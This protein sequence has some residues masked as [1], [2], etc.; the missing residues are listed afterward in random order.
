MDSELLTL[1]S[2]AAI[3]KS[4]AYAE[5]T[6]KTYASMRL[7]YLRLCAYFGFQPVP[8]SSSTVVLYVTFLARSL[9]PTSLPG[10]L[11]IVRLMHCEL[12]LTN[13]LD[14]CDVRWVRT[15]IQRR[16][17]QPPKQKL[18]ITPTILHDMYLQLDLSD[19]YV[20][21]FWAA[22]LVGFFAFLRKSSLLPKDKTKTAHCLCIGDIG[23]RKD[24]GLAMLT[25]R[26][27]KTIQFGQRVLCI[28]LSI[29]SN[30]ALCPVTALRRLLSSLPSSLPKDTP[31]FSFRS[32]N[33]P[34]AS[35]TYHT[36]IKT[37][38]STLKRAGY[39][40]LDYSGHSFR[41]GGCSH[42]FRLGVPAA[43]IKSRGDWR[44]SAYERYIT[45]HEQMNINVA[46][47]LVS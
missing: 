42:A 23:F 36:F 13:P 37:L 33:S 20:L 18:A 17:G 4:A 14:N 10:Y 46:R 26:H 9:K 44:S 1:R 5:S 25:V 7:A 47:I 3:F 28:P 41:R 38:K 21:A 11:N 24:D 32:G 35:L 19:S 39:S 16:L 31:L 12:G 2:E 34:V 43:L 29:H 8:A 15:G 27:T 6:K 40:P 30:P 22:C 45:I